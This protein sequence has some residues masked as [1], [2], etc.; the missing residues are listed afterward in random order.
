MCDG[1]GFIS[2]KQDRL[3]VALARRLARPVTWS[4]VAVILATVT[5]LARLFPLER[6][7]D[8]IEGMVGGLGV[9]APFVFAGAY[10][11]AVVLLVPGSAVTL[12]AGA[13]FG[14][15]WGL[16]AA[17][18]GSTMGA[19][20]A[21]LVA[22]L[23]GRDRFAQ[24][25]ERHPRFRAV[26]SAISDGGWKVVAML[27]LTPV[28]PFSISNYLFGLTAIRFAPYVLASW[29]FMLPG[30]FM[31]VYFGHV[32]KE[33]LAAARFLAAVPNARRPRRRARRER[34]SSSR[35]GKT[36][37]ELRAVLGDLRP[38][39]H[40]RRICPRS[41][42]RRDGRHRQ[43]RREVSS[44]LQRSAALAMHLRACLLRSPRQLRV[45]PGRARDAPRD[46][47]AA[48]TCGRELANPA[49]TMR[50]PMATTKLSIAAAS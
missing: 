25:I 18:L 3:T 7:L 42:A 40:R 16:V 10:A 11:I 15:V 29:L 4:S 17:S 9:A 19:S 12:A 38:R 27:R 8:W 45:R 2:K 31:Y 47:P 26:D 48:R 32:G 50:S 20:A 33:G 23:A 39:P 46:G 30:G 34:I 43:E 6:A 36:R 28:V 37:R 13:V 49:C 44:T 41:G 5:V 1:D 21:F 24:M 35:L 22:R 14:P